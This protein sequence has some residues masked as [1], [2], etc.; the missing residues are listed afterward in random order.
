MRIHVIA[1]GATLAAACGGKDEPTPAAAPVAAGAAAQPTSGAGS[2]SAKREPLQLTAKIEDALPPVFDQNVYP[3]LKAKCA[4]CHSTATQ[5][6]PKA[7]P[8]VAADAAQAYLAAI[9]DQALTGRFTPDTAGILARV[10]DSGPHKGI[11]YDEKTEKPGILAWL[12]AESEFST[13]RHHFAESDFVVDATGEKTRDPFQS[14]VVTQAGLGAK[15]NEG[16]VAPTASCAKVIAPDYGLR[17]LRLSAIFTR[18]LKHYALFQDSADVGEQ[19]ATV[20]DCVGKEK[21]RIT[22]I[23]DNVVTLQLTPEQLPNTAPV[24]PVEKSIPVFPPNQGATI[25]V[26]TGPVAPPPGTAPQTNIPPPPPP[27]TKSTGPMLQ[28][29]PPPTEPPVQHP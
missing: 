3:T 7:Y 28:N 19:L 8:F 26:P 24:A 21:A 2:G 11:K 13:I 27:T 1:L 29:A 10:D 20:H 12:H 17:D 4:R 23:S 6:D 25:S 9:R 15:T 22:D 18:G 5:A 16:A 14:F